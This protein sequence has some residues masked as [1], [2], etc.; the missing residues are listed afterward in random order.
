[1]TPKI[2][3]DHP[4]LSDAWKHEVVSFH[5]EGEVDERHVDLGLRHRETNVVTWLRFLG[6]KDVYFSGAPVSHGLEITD[7][8]G[9][10]LEGVTVQLSNFENSPDQVRLLARDVDRQAGGDARCS[11]GGTPDSARS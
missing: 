1:M 3:P 9:R 6:V 4:I 8:R 10:Q 11:R 7:V 5:C 2:D